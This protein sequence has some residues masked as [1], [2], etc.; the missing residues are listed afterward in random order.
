[1]TIARGRCRSKNPANCPYHGSSAD[2]HTRR[3]RDTMIVARSVFSAA[4][5]DEKLVAYLNLSEAEEA[6]YG[7]EEGRRSLMEHIEKTPQSSPDRMHWE[8]MLA[9]ADMRREFIESG[10]AASPTATTINFHSKLSFSDKDGTKVVTLGTGSV[11][12]EEYVF[13]WEQTEGFVSCQK[14]DTSVA[15]IL[16]KAKN[17]SSAKNLCEEWHQKATSSVSFHENKDNS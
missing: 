1:M 16:G 6:Y 15:E 5:E 10:V 7:T 4:S 11:A 13:D 17:I 14:N 9:K 3:L 8:E 12:G 2:S